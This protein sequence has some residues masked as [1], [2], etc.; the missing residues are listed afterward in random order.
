M[1]DDPNSARSGGD[2]GFFP[3]GAMEPTVEDAAFSLKIGELSQP[4][5]SAYGWHIV[6]AIERDTVKTRA[7][8]DSLDA[9]GGRCSRC[10][11]ATS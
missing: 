2:L 3:R 5:R 9:K 10:T 4:V 7:G 1:S 6:E 8:K 11:R